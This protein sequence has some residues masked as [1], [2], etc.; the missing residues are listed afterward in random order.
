[1]T[2]SSNTKTNVIQI[3]EELKI[4]VKID[5]ESQKSPNELILTNAVK[6]LLTIQRDARV[7]GSESSSDTRIKNLLE[8]VSRMDI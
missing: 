4:E 6:E 7:P 5:E 2:D 1:M 3:L 8:A